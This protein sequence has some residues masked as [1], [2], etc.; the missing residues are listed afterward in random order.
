MFRFKEDQIVEHYANRDDIEMMRQLG[1]HPP[2]A[3]PGCN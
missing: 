3:P 2:I 1:L